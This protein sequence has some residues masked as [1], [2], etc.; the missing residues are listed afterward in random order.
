MVCGVLLDCFFDL[1]ATL[2]VLLEVFSKEHQHIV[3]SVDVL[4]DVDHE[5]QVL[6]V[7][8][9]HAS[10]NELFVALTVKGIKRRIFIRVLADCLDVSELFLDSFILV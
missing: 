3:R 10:S 7:Q 4:A 6:F 9:L 1:Y 8:G 5:D 2:D